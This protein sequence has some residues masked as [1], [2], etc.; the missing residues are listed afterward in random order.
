MTT[1]RIL[2]W[3]YEGRS[4]D[5]LVRDAD[6]ARV[7]VVV[8][9]RLT[10]ISRKRG[11]SKTALA[12][13]LSSAGIAYVHLKALGNPKDNRP[14]FSNP[15]SAEGRNAH[16]RFAAEVLSSDEARSAMAEVRKIAGHGPLFLLCFEAD[17]ATCHR[18]LIR[19]AIVASEQLDPAMQ[20]V[21]V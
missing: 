17:D 7:R 5:D 4:V 19:D 13:S 16:E 3:G 18:A 20:L 10:P 8:D 2:G 6:A 14:G 15:H 1:D 21:E 12:A 9:V 11:F